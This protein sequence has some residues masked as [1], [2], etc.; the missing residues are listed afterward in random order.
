M[1]IYTKRYYFFYI[2]KPYNSLLEAKSIFVHTL[3]LSKVHEQF[4]HDFIKISL[5]IQ[6]KISR[7]RKGGNETDL[8]KQIAFVPNAVIFSQLFHFA[9]VQLSPPK[10]HL[11]TGS[12][13][14]PHKTYR[15]C[16]R[17]L[18]N[19]LYTFLLHPGRKVE[20]KKYQ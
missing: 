8:D 9:L 18:L 4:Q 5:K 16:P 14:N 19:I 15:R 17:R 7:A 3:P 2:L 11:D 12:K 1:W 6:V 20:K 13:M 10:N